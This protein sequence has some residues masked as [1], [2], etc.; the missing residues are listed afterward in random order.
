ME[1]R[2]FMKTAGLGALGVMLAGNGVLAADEK[3]IRWGLVGTGKRCVQHIKVIQKM[4]QSRIVA[5][6]DIQQARLDS[7]AAMC[8]A[9]PP[10]G[11]SD[12][13]ELLKRDDL[14]VILVA[15]PNYVHHEVVIAALNSGRPVLTEKPMG[16][17]V[18]ECNDMIATAKKSGKTLQVGLQLRYA[19]FYQKVHSLLRDGTIGKLKFVWFSEFR[20]DWAKQST[21]PEI[22]NKI[23]WRFY[24]KLSGGT[25]LEKS[26]HYFDLFNWFVGTKALRVTGMGGINYYS[27]GRETL[28]HASIVIEY[29]GDC[30]ATHGLSMYSPHGQGFRLIGET[31]AL[32]L[33]WETGAINLLRLGKQPEVVKADVANQDTGGHIGTF[34]MHQSF[35]ECLRTG[36][37]PLTDPEVGKESIRVGL[38]AEL[39][40][41]EKRW[42][43]MKE[44]EA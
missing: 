27:N 20:G 40:V 33:D 25:L 3:K 11:Y 32:D 43:E 4:P 7:A 9:D 23:N 24:N 19:P 16:I 38:A 13:K 5:L 35:L 39:A 2:E 1:R 41:K 12:Y 21:D 36:K 15:T 30:K 31:G 22:D 17:T 28:D 8:K 6:C 34:E 10:T 29:E 26:C 37:P 44:I 18:A 14:D 42:V